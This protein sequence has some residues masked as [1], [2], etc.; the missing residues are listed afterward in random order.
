MKTLPVRWSDPARRD[1]N[2]LID[3]IARASG[4][5]TTALRYADRIEARCNSI[6][7]VPRGGRS[8]D[9]LLPGLR[10]VPFER[11][12]LICYTIES[13]AVWI[14]NVLHGGRDVDAALRGVAPGADE[15]E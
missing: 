14:T 6:G 2:E 9:D 1:V 4:S 10:T 8:R 13:G 11:S 5:V 3:Y 7:D 12:V 15:A